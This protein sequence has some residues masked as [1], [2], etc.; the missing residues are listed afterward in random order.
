MGKTM[1]LR[2][3]RY[4]IEGDEA[5][6]K[7]W[8]PLVFPEEQYNVARPSDFWMNCLDA[9]GET[10]RDLGRG[11]EAEDLY[12]SLEAL[13]EEEQARAK[14][15]LGLLVG[16]CGERGQG[17]VLLVD[18]VDLVLDRLSDHQWS[19]RQ[20]LSEEKRLVLI[21]ASAAALEVS[22][23]YGAAFYDFFQVH[24]LTGLDEEQARTLLIALAESCGTPQAAEVV[25][26]DPGRFH[27]LHQLTGGNPRTLVL[28]H[29]VLATEKDGDVHQ[30]LE[31]LLDL[32]TPLYKARIETFSPQAQQVFDALA[33]GWDPL[34][35]DQLARLTRLHVNAVSSQLN[36]LV[37]QGMVQKVPYPP[38]KRHG[39]M[40]AERFFNIWYLMRA[41][42][43]VKRKLL[44][45]VRFL[46]MFY[47]AEGLGRRAHRYLALP[48]PG[49]DGTC[50]Q[51][52]EL[53]FTY[54]LAVEDTSL[55]Q[56]LKLF[57]LELLGSAGQD[58]RRELSRHL[59]LEGEDA[60]L[61]PAVDHL[62]QLR[63]VKRL[64]FADDISWSE[65]A[66]PEEMWDLL[67]GA[68]ALPVEVKQAVAERLEGAD[69]EQLGVLLDAL[70]KEAS[71][72][73]SILGEARAA[74]LSEALQRGY[75]RGLTDVDGAKAAAH[76]LGA[77]D[78]PT[79][80]AFYGFAN[81]IARD[82][83]PEDLKQLA[84]QEDTPM[85]K[86]YTL[87]HEAGTVNSARE[88]I[89][90]ITSANELLADSTGRI[91]SVLTTELGWEEAAEAAFRQ[92]IKMHRSNAAWS[93]VGLTLLKQERFEEAEQAFRR[94]LELDATVL[95][96]WNGLWAT[97]GAQK[98]WKDAMAAVRQARTLAPEDPE[99]A[100]VLAYL[101]YEARDDDLEAEVLAREAVTRH[102]DPVRCHF[103]LACV[104][105]AR[106]KWHEAVPSVL[107]VIGADPA[108]LEELWDDILTLFRE[109]VSAGRAKEA[110]AL[111]DEAG[112]ADR[113]RPLRE[114]LRVVAE[115]SRDC[116]LRIAPEVR[117][118]AE[119]VL[120]LLV[121][122][123]SPGDQES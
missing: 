22:Y 24:E 111:L 4:A 110:G 52:A 47:G 31:R 70:R 82:L 59:D 3:L 50:G 73:V 44:W 95:H 51:N 14:R 123:A 65:G 88:M 29:N 107:Q 71:L 115:G 77:P 26:N 102:P 96:C 114:A 92:A 32:C 119:E 64:V 20:V 97:L 116:L 63:E 38:G 100:L 93:G 75:I 117:Q 91:G 83:T 72:L 23:D 113:W 106:G 30:D 45:L 11:E 53:A 69:V 56:A 46:K 16:W 103:V 17:L 87:L 8:L 41:S 5:L 94:A 27:S 49:G 36:R 28:L 37:K 7:N 35:A 120:E 86:L 2:R 85:G 78:L 15:T 101:H 98:R 81:I 43:R 19:V 109:A 39:F 121:Q 74:Q 55:A 80:V 66:S 62:E 67:G 1:L 21:C 112:I 79:F 58:L 34:T 99:L 118:T 25:K 9:L 68:W 105:V 76:R 42:R 54:A 89:T 40:V 108:M 6:S 60:S 90:Q 13:P 48:P 122:P 61:V 84:P 10:L 57:G 12:S 104:L 33:L 18:N